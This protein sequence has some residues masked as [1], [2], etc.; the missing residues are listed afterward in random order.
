MN[1]TYN[2]KSS[3]HVNAP[4][5]INRV[6]TS[7]LSLAQQDAVFEALKF[8]SEVRA[9]L[10][11]GQF[12][13]EGDG[14]AVVLDYEEIE[15]RGQQRYQQLMAQVEKFR[16]KFLES[17]YATFERAESASDF[18]QKHYEEMMGAADTAWG[19][20]WSQVIQGRAST[21]QLAQ[22]VHLLCWFYQRVD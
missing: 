18:E 15:R 7:G 1:R 13:I 17:F 19:I 11:A 6:R 20:A 3:L 9:A 21:S 5:V 4:A 2:L 8:P 22:L 16:G 12:T 14:V 10:L